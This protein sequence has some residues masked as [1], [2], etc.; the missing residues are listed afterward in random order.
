MR[1]TM[2]HRGPDDF[3][4]WYSPDFRVGLAHR[5]LAI[6]DLSPL[7]HQPM[8]DV[9]GNLV[10]VF[11]GEIYNFS[12]LR[13]YLE[14]N[15][16]TFKSMSDTEVILAAYREWGLD[17]LEHLNGM[18]AFCIY[19]DRRRILFLA[20]DRVGEK[21]LYYRHSNGR[22]AFASELRALLAD[23][24]TPR[25]LNPDALNYY[26]AYGH[27]PCP[28][29]IVDGIH[30]LQPGSAMVL[31]IDRG[32]L[33]QWKYWDLPEPAGD[34][35]A[36]LEEVCAQ[37]ESLMR[38]SVRRQMVSDVP[39][40]VLLSGGCDSSLVAAFASEVSS[41]RLR[42]FTISFPGHKKYDE[43]PFARI[44]ADHL[45]TEHIEITMDDPPAET[46]LELAERFDEPI[47]DHA[48][49]PT[50]LVSRAIKEYATVAL[51]GDGGDE[52]Y[53]G[54][55]H[56]SALLRL[57][58]FRRFIPSSL[59]SVIA[60]WALRSIPVGTRYRNHFIGFETGFGNS[61]AHINLY[62][63]KQSRMQLLNPEII[64][65]I[66]TGLPE[67]GKVMDCVPRYSLLRQMMQTD[68]VTT[69]TDGYLAKVDRAS[70]LASIE[71]RA[72]FLDYRMIEFAYRSVPDRY[73][74]A[75][76]QTKILTRHSAK[77]LLPRRLNLQRKQGFTMPIS[78]WLGGNWGRFIESVLCEEPLSL[79]NRKFVV[80]LFDNDWR[81]KSNSN[82]LYAL[83]ILELWCRLN[84]ATI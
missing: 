8:H 34:S 24:E 7:G 28:M 75:R 15:G 47:A 81:I 29:S 64:S 56:Y 76:G 17:C 2:S 14:E 70:M 13:K 32:S 10:I 30:K 38:D 36:S 71:I 42:T 20:R 31:D 3:G 58:Q 12:D 78:K 69:L 18:F 44:V 40:G 4:E 46:I 52:L 83:T 26:L 1:D 11:N 67:R 59:R 51:S 45:D 43:A 55:P 9:S 33:R 84:R 63:D 37:F 72:P 48:F 23:P 57:E 50:Y 74:V 39:I 77:R 16:H 61:V 60:V 22:F 5:R 79:L 6:I 19:D 65:T 68:F 82:R 35:N 25:K 62:F 27:V 21:P 41:K 49:V 80:K 73:K 66:D 53:G 54:Y